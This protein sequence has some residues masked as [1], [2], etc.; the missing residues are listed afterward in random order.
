MDS[1][2]QTE[3]TSHPGEPSSSTP[4]TT[5]LETKVL[6]SSARVKAAKEK[7][8]ERTEQTQPSGSSSTKRAREITAGKGKGKEVA[9]GTPRAN[10]RC[11]YAS[12]SYE[13][14]VTEPP[15]YSEHA[16][17]RILQVLR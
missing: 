11:A 15:R 14:L 1:T 12:T 7:E 6:R 5:S 9:E 13:V 8:R 16:V 10:K 3:A 17:R 4:S 2:Q